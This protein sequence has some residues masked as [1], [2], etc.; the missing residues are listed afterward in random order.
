MTDCKNRL[1]IINH[2]PPPFSHH[3]L[4]TLHP[5]LQISLHR[6]H[7]PLGAEVEKEDEEDSVDSQVYDVDD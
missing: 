2:F 3:L 6:I 1:E 5:S 4:Q 7:S